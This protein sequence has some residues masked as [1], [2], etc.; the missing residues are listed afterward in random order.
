M[1]FLSS[2]S[3]KQVVH[4]YRDQR[5]IIS[6]L[7]PCNMSVPADNVCLPQLSCVTVLTCVVNNPQHNSS[8]DV[9]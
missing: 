4:S 8:N 3:E 2:D 6:E 1:N 7:M 9:D 5:D